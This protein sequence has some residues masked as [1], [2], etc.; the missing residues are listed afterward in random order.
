[1]NKEYVERSLK[2]TLQKMWNGLACDR[3]TDSALQRP[4]RLV[5]VI[6]I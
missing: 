6:K 5:E 3:W 2:L 4:Y 1:M